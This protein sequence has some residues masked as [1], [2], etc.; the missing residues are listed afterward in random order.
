[1]DTTR[2]PETGQP[3]IV[4]S[5]DEQHPGVASWRLALP[6]LRGRTVVLREPAREDVAP[7][8]ALL[9]GDDTPRFGINEPLS[10]KV[11]SGFIDRVRQARFGGA[12]FTYAITRLADGAV[13]GLLQ[14]RQLDSTFETAECECLFERRQP[15]RGAFLEAARLAGS[16]AFGA[17]GAR[18]LESRVALGDRHANS[19]LR[20]LGA[21]QEA[22]L[23]QSMRRG[24]EY[25]D[26]ALWALMKEDWRGGPASPLSVWIH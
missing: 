5:T 16:F 17:V 25:V 20:Q 15:G 12:S 21:E 8:A 18:R 9:G 23:R 3:V 13:A 14:V 6:T 4:V 19:A 26:Q 11:L 10:N 22:V 7:L 2:E 24:S 1:V